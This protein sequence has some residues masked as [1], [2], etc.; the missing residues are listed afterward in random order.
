MSSKILKDFTPIENILLENFAAGILPYDELRLA[1]F[2]ERNTTGYAT[3][4]GR[5]KY[6]RKL[7]HAE[8]AQM[9]RMK[10]CTVTNK[11]NKMLREKKIKKDGRKYMLNHNFEDWCMLEKATVENINKKSSEK[12]PKMLG[13]TT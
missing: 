8:I 1:L 13:I 7:T 10:R 11:I 5:R 6:T 3:K 12:Q 4:N 9:I 2:I